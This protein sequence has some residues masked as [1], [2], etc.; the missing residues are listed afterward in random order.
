M[1]IKTRD[2]VSF[3]STYTTLDALAMIFLF[4]LDFF[5]VFYGGFWLLVNPFIF[6]VLENE[7]ERLQK[8]NIT[9]EKI[10]ILFNE[11]IKR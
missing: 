8:N 4:F 2:F 9:K 6:L 3:T 1:S 10:Q 11:T 5:K 7:G